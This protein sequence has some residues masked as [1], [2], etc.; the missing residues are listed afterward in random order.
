M[1]DLK[2]REAILKKCPKCQ[3]KYK[4]PGALS[5]KDSK[6]VICP[7][8]GHREALIEFNYEDEDIERILKLIRIGMQEK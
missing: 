7:E 2:T 6:T 4:G 8:C 3:T 5:R 1:N